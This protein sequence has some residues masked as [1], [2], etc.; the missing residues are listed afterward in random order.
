[1]WF[2]RRTPLIGLL[3][4]SLAIILR[5]GA[6]GA[7]QEPERTPDPKP[8]KTAAST[9][10]APKNPRPRSCEIQALGVVNRH[11][12][13][14][15]ATHPSR[16]APFHRFFAFHPRDEGFQATSLSGDQREN[17]GMGA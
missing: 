12:T 11:A 5:A 7:A 16:G 14:A 6:P 17:G 4:L 9:D 1:M 3:V 8:P 13:S 15:V 10:D 2:L